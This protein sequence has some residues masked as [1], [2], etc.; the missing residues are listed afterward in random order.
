MKVIP[1]NIYSLLTPI[2]LAYW[3]SCEG[4]FNKREGRVEIATDSFTPE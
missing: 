4:H 2:A 3:L 1:S